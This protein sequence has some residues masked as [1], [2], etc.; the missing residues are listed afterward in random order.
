MSKIRFIDVQRS[1]E[2]P[3]I[4]NLQYQYAD[5]PMQA[6]VK[7]TRDGLICPACSE[8]VP[9]LNATARGLLCP[10]CTS[11]LSKAH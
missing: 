3:G 7:T 2:T 1:F 6:K 8:R 10:A 9:L 11:W 4:V 5:A